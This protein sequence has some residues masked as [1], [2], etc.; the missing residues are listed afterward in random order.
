MFVVS[1]NPHEPNRLP[2]SP[3]PSLHTVFSRFLRPRTPEN[4]NW[5]SEFDLAFLRFAP[6]APGFEPDRRNPSA[7]ALR[8]KLWAPVRRVMAAELGQQT[9]EFSA[10]V[11]RAA[12]DSYLAL[13]DLVERSRAPEDQRS[14]SEKKID[15]LKFIAKTRQ[16]M[17]RIHVLAKVSVC[18]PSRVPLGS[19]RWKA[20]SFLNPCFMNSIYSLFYMH[21]GLQHARA[22]IFDVPAAIEILLSGGYKRLP[23]CIED[24]VVQS[25]LSEDE[26]KPTLRKLD[27]I[28]RSKLLE[29][30]LPKE[31]S[32]VTISD[33]IAVLRVDGEFKVFLTLGYRGHLSLWRILHIEL[34]VGEKSGTIKLEETRRYA[35]G[36]DLERRMAA[37]ENPFLILYTVLHELC[38]ALVMDTVL[39]Q[40]QVLR[41]GRWK[42]AIR[43]EL[44][45][46]GTAAQGAN[47]SALQL[48][49]EGELDST[50]LKT[51]GLKIIYWLDADKNA[52]GSDF[53]S[54]PFLKLE[55]GQ[56]TQINIVPNKVL[57]FILYR[58]NSIPVCGSPAIGRYRRNR[59]SAIDFDRRWSIEGERRGRRRKGRYMIFPGSPRDSSPARFVTRAIRRSRAVLRRRASFSPCGETSTV[60]NKHEVHELSCK[61]HISKMQSRSVPLG[62]AVCTGPLVTGTWTTLYRAVP[63]K[64]SRRSISAID[65]RLREKKGRRR[66]RGKRRK[67]KKRRRREKYL[68][69]P[70]CPRP[71]AV[72][73]LTRGRF[74][75]CARRRNVSLRGE[76]DRGGI[77]PFVLFF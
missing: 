62:M 2:L 23:K 31:I 53:S 20:A 56:D 75:S 72:A 61:L 74:F 71:H 44:I 64:S 28:L 6:A 60:C 43:F 45:S 22:P 32:E 24:L 9:V 40:V 7:P 42:D 30:V 8:P 13:K 26:Q 59:Q 37:A 65:G 73:A 55:P 18:V 12:E 67:K 50:G 39:R 46:D 17:L 35:L 4:I 66:R 58:S 51:P 14:D 27:T 34:L 47:T 21:E 63:P 10:L 68:L 1:P 29:V 48:A 54:R 76:K 36:D 70:R 16:R 69:S 25:T 52:G 19:G 38:V 33:G 41:Q 11:R 3:P 15:L 77:T 57:R 5:S 49:Q